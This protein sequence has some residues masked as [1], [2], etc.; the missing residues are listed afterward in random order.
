ML[1]LKLEKLKR[2]SSILLIAGMCS[3]SCKKKEI[4]LSQN[5][6]GRVLD[7]NSGSPVVGASITL[8]ASFVASGINNTS[9]QTLGTTSTNSNGYYSF[10]YDRKQF[11]EIEISATK[12]SY[13]NFSSE[14]NITDVKSDEDFRFDFRMIAKAWVSLTIT[15]SSATTD[16]RFW[17]RNLSVSENCTN[18]CNNKTVSFASDTVNYARICQI[19]GNQFHRY[20]TAWVENSQYTP[21]IDSVFVAAG[22]TAQ[23]TLSY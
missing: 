5:W 2:L 7:K 11:T 4:D 21:T 14:I 3:M 18:C 8:K 13:A 1:L 10:E 22:D 16:N 20:L 12:G 6:T 17:Y 9:L 15:H 19:E 23:V